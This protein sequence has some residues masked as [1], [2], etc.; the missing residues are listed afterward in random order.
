[1]YGVRK[2]NAAPSAS[3]L[4][5]VDRGNLHFEEEAFGNFVKLTV[6]AHM[7]ARDTLLLLFEGLS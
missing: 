2:I 6:A 3:S 1:M 7:L 4:A 5:D